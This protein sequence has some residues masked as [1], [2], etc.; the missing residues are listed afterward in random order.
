MSINPERHFP[1]P[2]PH[3]R[4][5][6]FKPENLDKLAEGIGEKLDKIARAPE[7]SEAEKRLEGS[8]AYFKEKIQKILRVNGLVYGKDNSEILNKFEFKYKD[9]IVGYVATKIFP[10]L[11]AMPEHNAIMEI[12][13]K[14]TSSSSMTAEITKEAWRKVLNNIS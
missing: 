14:S 9:N 2:T 5:P 3:V 1:V 7:K 6:S 8:A 4:K 12:I 10:E 11:L 13:K